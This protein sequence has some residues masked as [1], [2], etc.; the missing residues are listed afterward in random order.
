[1]ARCDAMPPGRGFAVAR[2]SNYSYERYQRERA[3]AEKREAKRTA[4]AAGK[5]PSADDAD[6][7]QA[8]AGASLPPTPPPSED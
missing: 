8:D 6:A 2:R 4:R 5:R 1:M 3:R 7:P